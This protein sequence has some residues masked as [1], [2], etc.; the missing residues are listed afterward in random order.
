MS[1]DIIETIFAKQYLPDSIFLTT[2]IQAF[3]IVDCN[4]RA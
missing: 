3:S 1:N 2:E 4:G